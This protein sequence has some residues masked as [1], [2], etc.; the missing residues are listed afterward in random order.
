MIIIVESVLQVCHWPSFSIGRERR[1]RMIFFCPP[2]H[3]QDNSKNGACCPLIDGAKEKKQLS[4]NQP[5]SKCLYVL[6]RVDYFTNAGF[7][8]LLDT[9]LFTF[10][11]KKEVKLESKPFK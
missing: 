8:K 1:K 3:K 6:T 4:Y 11:R 5:Y 7:T 9:I 2:V 10:E